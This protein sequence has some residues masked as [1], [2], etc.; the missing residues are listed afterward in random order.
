M[1]RSSH[2]SAHSSCSLA[3]SNIISTDSSSTNIGEDRTTSQT[4]VELCFLTMFIYYQRIHAPLLKFPRGVFSGRYKFFFSFFF[5][6][7][8]ACL[9]RHSNIVHIAALQMFYEKGNAFI[10]LVKTSRTHTMS[11]IE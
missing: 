2:N 8:A 1:L 9:F 4:Q 11:F 6:C 10:T 3:V 5:L 7:V